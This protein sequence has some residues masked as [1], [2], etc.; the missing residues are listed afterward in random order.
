MIPKP[1]KEGYNWFVLA[2]SKT[3]YILNLTPDECLAGQKGHV[4]DETTTTRGEHEMTWSSVR[5]PYVDSC[6]RLGTFCQ[7]SEVQNAGFKSWMGAVEGGVNCYAPCDRAMQ[8]WVK[9]GVD[10]TMKKQCES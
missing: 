2:D 3:S 4:V 6:Q 7:V 1:V 5:F 10:D 9:L 8:G